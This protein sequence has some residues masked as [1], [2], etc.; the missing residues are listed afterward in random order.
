ML[1]SAVC[2]FV[3]APYISD[4]VLYDPDKDLIPEPGP[5]LPDDLGGALGRWE[6]SCTI[7][8][9]YNCGSWARHAIG[10]DLGGEYVF[11]RN[12][13]GAVSGADQRGFVASDTL[14]AFDMRTGATLWS[15]PKTGFPTALAGG[16]VALNTSGNAWATTLFAPDGSIVAQNLG[17]SAQMANGVL[18][19]VP[20]DVQ[21][22][23]WTGPT[24]NGLGAIV[25]MEASS[26]PVGLASQVSGGGRNAAGRTYST[27]DAAAIAALQEHN[28]VSIEAN[29]EFGGSV[30]RQSTG[31][32]FSTR[33]N[34]NLQNT[35]N[36]IPSLCS[37]EAVQSGRYHTH[38]F[39]G[40]NTFSGP[41]V[42]KANNDSYGGVYRPHFVGTPC[43]EIHKL[44][45]PDSVVLVN[46][47][48]VPTGHGIYFRLPERTSTIKVCTP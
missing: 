42:V 26:S 8:A 35:D 10:G 45:G 1:F 4:K 40:N 47:V 15:S 28:P 16:G 48:P 25:A 14:K 6:V 5:A 19:L 21:T 7:Y 44:V 43:G 32:Y 12:Y 27:I 3:I 39:D 46:G 34:I 20:G 24:G 33:P 31:R 23:L 9:S 13:I 37:S 41:D 11:P 30:C 22:D 17:R 18:G 38:G 29:H 36:V 2:A